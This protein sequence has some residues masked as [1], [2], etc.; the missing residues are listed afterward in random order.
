MNRHWSIAGHGDDVVKLYDLTDLC[1]D[2]TSVP[3]TNPF[4]VPVGILLYR[5]ARNMRQN[6]GR[7][8]SGTIRTLL[9]NCLLLLDRETHSQV[10][11][12]QHY[13]K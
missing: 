7:K 13:E 1:G 4:T 5:V 9:E 10:R 12:T 8:K 11:I 3:S 2:V 6:A